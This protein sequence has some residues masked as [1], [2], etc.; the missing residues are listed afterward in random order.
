M[1]DWRKAP[2][3]GYVMLFSTTCDVP[4]NFMLLTN[5]VIQ[6]QA[7]H[8]DADVPLHWT[9]FLAFNP[10]SAQAY[11]ARAGAYAK[12]G[13]AEKAIADERSACNLGLRAACDMA[14]RPRP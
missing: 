6:A 7:L 14:Q 12:L 5:L 11:H 4:D 8:R 1:S 2:E 10:T 13:E 3:R 9:R